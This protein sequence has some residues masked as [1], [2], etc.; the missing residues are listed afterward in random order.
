M[1]WL[2]AQK[3]EMASQVQIVISNHFASILTGKES[4]LLFFR[5]TWIQ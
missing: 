3:M 2:L 1:E 4:I 5:Y